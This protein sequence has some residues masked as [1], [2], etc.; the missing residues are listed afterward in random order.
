VDTID[1]NLQATNFSQGIAA[2][3]GL[4]ALAGNGASMLVDDL[5]G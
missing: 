5:I 3:A 1:F 4:D 2:P